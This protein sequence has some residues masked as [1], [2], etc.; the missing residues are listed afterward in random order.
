MFIYNLSGGDSSVVGYPESNRKV[1]DH[2][3]ILELPKRRCVL[4]KD[5]LR[6][7]PL[8]PS[9]PL[10][11]EALPDERL[12]NRTQKSALHWCDETQRAWFIEMIYNE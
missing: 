3:S 5:T 8:G 10:F 9:S 11:V 4:G 6:L 2:G 1:A 12:A 7:F